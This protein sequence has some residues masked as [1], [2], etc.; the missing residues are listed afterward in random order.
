MARAPMLAEDEDERSPQMVDALDQWRRLS[1]D[2]LETNSEALAGDFEQDMVHRY[3]R[4]HEALGTSEEAFGE[5]LESQLKAVESG[6]IQTFP[7]DR[8]ARGICSEY[9]G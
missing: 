1:L 5:E 8:P 3:V 4:L 9:Y 2:A 6:Q 7:E